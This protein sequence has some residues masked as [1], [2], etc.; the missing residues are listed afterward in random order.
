MKSHIT[1][2]CQ[3]KEKMRSNKLL[4]GYDCQNYQKQSPQKQIKPGVRHLPVW[5]DYDTFNIKKNERKI[6]KHSKSRKVWWNIHVV[7]HAYLHCADYG[8]G[9]LKQTELLQ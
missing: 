1:S 2:L 9:H 3:I 4:P 5:F 6:S 7:V 8:R